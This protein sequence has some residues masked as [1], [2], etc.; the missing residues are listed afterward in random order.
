MLH[1]CYADFRFEQ[2]QLENAAAKHQS[3]LMGSTIGQESVISPHRADPWTTLLPCA[4]LQSV[5]ASFH[6]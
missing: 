4:H 5:E 3:S 1:W 2:K 6:G